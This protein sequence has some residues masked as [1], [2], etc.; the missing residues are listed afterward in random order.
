MRVPLLS[1]LLLL[2]LVPL[3]SAYSEP[4]GSSSGQKSG[5]QKAGSEKRTAS[6]SLPKGYTL[7]NGRIYNAKGREM[8]RVVI[9]P[10]G[11]GFS[12]EQATRDLERVMRLYDQRPGFVRDDYVGVVRFTDRHYQADGRCSYLVPKAT[13]PSS[14]RRASAFL[15]GSK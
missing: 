8:V 6:P 9:Q 1:A 5:T 10:N 14:S 12:A 2:A 3:H 13:L 15:K 4:S 11:W 7:R